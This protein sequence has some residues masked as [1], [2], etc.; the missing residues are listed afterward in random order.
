MKK[1]LALLTAIFF[2]FISYAIPAKPGLI[3]ARQPDGSIINIYIQG[4]ERARIVFSQ[5][6][7]ILVNDDEGYYVFADVD[8]DGTPIATQIR[9]INLSDR[10]V[11][12]KQFLSTIN[13]QKIRDWYNIR[14][15]SFDTGI[16][17]VQGLMTTHFP[18][19]G[20]QRTL[21]ILV[22]FPNQS[23]SIENPNDYYSRMLN[24][25]GF[26]DYGA[27]GSARDYFVENSLGK[28]IPQF[29]VYGPVKLENDYSYYGEND[30]WGQ[31]VKPEFLAIDACTL[32]DD[33]I[34]FSIYDC[35]KDGFI[36]NV[37]IFYAGYGEADGGG[38]ETIWPHS[39]DLSIASKT[40]YYFDGLRLDHYACSNEIKHS[41]E[42]PDGIGTFC[43]EFGHVLGLPDLYATSYTTAYTPGRW[44]IMDAGSYNNSS[45]T[46]PYYS[47]FERYAL[48]W[49][50][51]E[52]VREGEK[53]LLPIHK[54]NFAYRAR[55][56]DYNEYFLI[57]NRQQEGYD[58]FLPGHGMLIWHIDYDMAVWDRNTVNNYASH[59]RVDLIE[60]D[61]IQSR[62]TAD[63]DAF[64][65][66]MNV[67]EFSCQTQPGFYRWDNEP[68]PL[69]FFNIKESEEGI[70]TFT[71]EKC[72]V[73]SI[74]KSTTDGQLSIIG[75]RVKSNDFS[76][77]LFDF[78]GNYIASV[79]SEG[80]ILPS[81]MYIAIGKDFH[82]KFIID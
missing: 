76:M 48:D 68:M 4:D 52:P 18:S 5:D 72:E 38:S 53:E 13:Q 2:N 16:F 79:D 50:D 22:E 59:Q 19:Y 6:S 78:K 24:E 82:K 42:E 57:E 62:E 3:E 51:P 81:G 1:Y 77:K 46:P 32:M 67:T 61:D 66:P 34:D 69:R 70:I 40:P 12:T 14:Q 47:A 58:A 44:D 31:D 56:L 8:Q 63:G 7:L 43:H 27:T 71:S 35:N 49:L 37:Y 65:G 45:R 80:V 75:H 15:D 60:A 64:P 25:E 54:S 21:V 11:Y 26:S 39:W 36:D 41:T 17:R 9:E 73:A 23:F 20:E 28:F 10:S 29:D 33:E 55:A 74:N 30:K